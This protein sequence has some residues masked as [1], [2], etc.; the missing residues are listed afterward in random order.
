MGWLTTMLPFQEFVIHGLFDVLKR[1]CDLGANVGSFYR[2]TLS[3]RF[4]RYFPWWNPH[5]FHQSNSVPQVSLFQ[6]V[7]INV[8]VALP[9]AKK[10][11]CFRMR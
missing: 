8:L 5:Q 7:P 3:K 11:H 6:A 4:V 9:Q 2:A 1:S 10:T